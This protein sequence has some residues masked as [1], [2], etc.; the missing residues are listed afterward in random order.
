MPGSAKPHP[1][2]SNYNPEQIGH[3]F[4][5]SEKFSLFTLRGRLTCHRYDIF[6]KHDAIALTKR[7]GCRKLL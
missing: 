3:A 1:A 2:S 6:A 4:L 7:F 5:V